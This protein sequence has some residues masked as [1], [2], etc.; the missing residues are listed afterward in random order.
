MELVQL[1]VSRLVCEDVRR[2]CRLLVVHLLGHHLESLVE[3]AN[4]ASQ[5]LRTP[6]GHDDANAHADDR[7]DQDSGAEDLDD[8]QSKLALKSLDCL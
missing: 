7:N 8:V 6:L 2:N 4:P 3:M 5:P 1:V